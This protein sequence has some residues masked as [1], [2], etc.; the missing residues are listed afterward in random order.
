[1]T[2]PN[3]QPAASPPTRP[4]QFTLRTLLLLFV[5]LGSSLAVFGGWG[6]VVFLVVVGFTIAAHQAE[7]LSS[8]MRRAFALACLLALLA[9]L[10]PGVEAVREGLGR[11]SC[12]KNLSYIQVALQCYHSD[13]G[14]YPPAY[15]ADKNGKPIHS[16]RVLILPYLYETALYKAYNFSE[17]WDGP[18]NKKLLAARP[19]YYACSEDPGTQN[20]KV[21][22]TSFVAVVGANAAWSGVKPKSTGEIRDVRNTI[23]VAEAADSGIAWTEP[24]DLSL[25]DLEAAQGHSQAIA[26]SSHHGLE[27][28][29]FFVYDR[30]AVAV[31][32]MASGGTSD[33]PLGSLSPEELRKAL[34]IGGFSE[35][36]KSRDGFR[37]RGRRPNW[38]NIAALAVWL[39][40]VGTLLTQAVR[41]RKT[42]STPPT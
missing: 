12:H 18:N 11:L 19:I 38:P 5:V 32:A 22:L 6:I 16:W 26:V 34:Q 28:G 20:A 29:F 42:W 17:P 40:S 3:P 41:S 9:L 37:D 8:A 27:K 36:I 35:D 14:R 2:A 1:M 24:R 33:L 21:G 31:V 4:F 7:S 39:L 13:Y 10:A 15:I 23:L 25:D 30:P